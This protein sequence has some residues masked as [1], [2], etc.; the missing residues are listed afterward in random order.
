MTRPV[1][2]EPGDGWLPGDLVALPGVTQCPPALGFPEPHDVKPRFVFTYSS[3]NIF[4]QR[5]RS[6]RGELALVIG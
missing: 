4:T 1:H 3:A 6:D 5:A 2:P